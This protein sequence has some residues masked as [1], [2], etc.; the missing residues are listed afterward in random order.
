MLTSLPSEIGQLE[1]L[2]ILDLSDNQLTSIP[3]EIGQL[4]KFGILDLQNNEIPETEIKK[5]KE[6]LP[7]C[8][9]YNDYE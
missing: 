3:V 4:G 1:N 7:N 5:I 6:L 2:E 8:K 9:I